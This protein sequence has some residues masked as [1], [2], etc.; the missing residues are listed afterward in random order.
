M[1]YFKEKI[2][3]R[4]SI[5]AITSSVVARSIFKYNVVGV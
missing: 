3:K 5:V 2:K 1:N 4:V